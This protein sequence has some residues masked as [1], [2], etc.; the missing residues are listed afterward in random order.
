MDREEL[1]AKSQKILGF[2]DE[3]M[4]IIRNDPK[5]SK[6]I[7]KGP[8][9]VRTKV[10]AEVVQAKNCPVHGEGAKYVIRGN[11]A[12][13]PQDAKNNMC[14]DCMP[15]IVPFQ[16]MVYDKVLEGE[17]VTGMEQFVRC[18]DTG[19]ECGGFGTAML[20]LTVEKSK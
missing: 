6:A 9:L 16:H 14:L 11:G 1:W 8:D 3:E 4:N 20:K 10:V 17:E 5:R 18:P 13:L 15:L 2:T 12:M 19:V 7:D